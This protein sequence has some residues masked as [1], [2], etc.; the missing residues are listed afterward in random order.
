ME[1]KMASFLK[2]YLAGA[3]TVAVGLAI[4]TVISPYPRADIGIK[5][6]DG[7]A[8]ATLSDHNQLPDGAIQK[9]LVQ[10]Y[11]NYRAG[12]TAVVTLTLPAAAPAHK[13]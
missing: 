12:N 3:G 5:F 6:G 9:A 8:V 10:A 13:L 11:E 4:G 2:G 1:D 7:A